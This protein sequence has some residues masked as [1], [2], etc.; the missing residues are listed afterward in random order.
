MAPDTPPDPLKTIIQI[1]IA[2]L[3]VIACARG[4][5]A[6]WRYYE[7]SDA[8]EQEVR[9]GTAKSTAELHRRVADIARERDVPVEYEN[10][11]VEPKPGQTVVTVSYVEAINLIPGVYT[12][13]QTF[14]VKV[15]MRVV[16]PLIQ[17]EP[18]PR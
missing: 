5:E 3:V 1:L 4:G 15:T 6:A 13:N 10:I 8:V 7:F 11:V 12:R 14:E 17:D 9:F 2:I 16:R 18:E